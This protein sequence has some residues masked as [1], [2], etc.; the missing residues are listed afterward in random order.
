MPAEAGGEALQSR[1]FLWLY[2]LAVAGGAIA[3]VPF[4]TILLPTRVTAMAGTGDIALLAYATFAGA[5]A[6]SVSNITFGW[7]SDVTRARVPWIAAGLVS[8]CLLLGAFGAVVSASAVILLLV[9][10][11]VALN[12]MLAPLA[13]WAGDEVPDA[14]KGTLGGLL[15]F[16]PAAGAGAGVLVTAPGLAAA[17]TRL[18][19]VALL[20][21]LCVTPVLLVGR[22]RTVAI[23][24]VEG[25]V[26]HA[27]RRPRGE[28]ARMWLARL[29]VQV[30]EAALFAY[31]LFWLRSIDPGMSDAQVAQIFGLILLGAV[32][33]ALGAGR[34]AD[35]HDRPF[36]PLALCA[37]T[38]AIGLLVMAGAPGLG[39]AIAGYMLFGLAAS[40]FLS[41]HSAQTLRVLP[42]A[43][44]RGRDLGL[45]N[46][47]NT[48]PSLVTPWLTLALVPHF[49]FTGLFIAL[50]A[51][52]AAATILLIGMSRPV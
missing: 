14:Q 41:L 32:P 52:A 40:V 4:L 38:A 33:L 10:W 5:V 12:M 19:L 24:S 18:W 35:R 1:R 29:M 49:G 16:A 47:T 20:V 23:S 36:T 8:S 25:S 17:D 7:A 44:S 46:L 6:A 28:V 37:G 50:A 9:A 45:F 31:L 27:R 11:Q 21:V 2:A 42:R 13:A 34:W 15:S 51:F 3:Y 43:R 48:A 26:D 39:T 30:S 22:P